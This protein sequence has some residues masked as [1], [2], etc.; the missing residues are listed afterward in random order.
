MKCFAQNFEFHFYVFNKKT[1]NFMFHYK[2]ANKSAALQLAAASAV[3]ILLRLSVAAAPERW[4]G[5]VI[6]RARAYLPF[7]AVVTTLGVSFPWSNWYNVV[8]LVAWSFRLCLHLDARGLYYRVPISTA[9]VWAWLVCCPAAMDDPTLENVCTDARTRVCAGVAFAA[10]CLETIA[11]YAKLKGRCLHPSAEP[12][13][14]WPWS[15]SRHP[16]YF[17]EVVFHAAVA[18][19]S[20][21]TVWVFRWIGL[22]FTLAAVFVL[23]GNIYQRETKGAQS[24]QTRAVKGDLQCLS[25]KAEV[26]AFLPVPQCLYRRCNYTTQ[27]ILSC[28]V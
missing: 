17:A 13:R 28:F 15:W 18:T 11:D 4:K 23:P 27:S 25:Y 16:N 5:G 14:S 21:G 9:P 3:A 10:V 24:L 6:E 8:L 19:G 2:D 12:F 20:C 1:K 22:C 26:S 7:M